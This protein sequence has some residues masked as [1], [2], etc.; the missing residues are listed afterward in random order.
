MSSIL[1]WYEATALF[2]DFRFKI[3]LDDPSLLG[4]KNMGEI[5]WSLT[6][7]HMHITPDW[8]KSDI[9][10]INLL[11]SAE[12]KLGVIGSVACFTVLLNGIL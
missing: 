9:A 11:I 5:N 12:E 4:V 7:S 1:K 6:S 2:Y 10:V 3:N 8:H